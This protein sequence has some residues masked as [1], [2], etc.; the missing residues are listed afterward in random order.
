MEDDL[1]EV[2]DGLRPVTPELV[3]ALLGVVEGL[4]S[5][6]AAAVAGEEYEAQVALSQRALT[7]AVGGGAPEEPVA[8][9]PPPEQAPEPA[10]ERT[11][12]PVSD[13]TPAPGSTAPDPMPTAPEP[14]AAGRLV[15]SVQERL[16]VPI[17]RLDELVRLVGETVAGQLR[18]GVLL[19]QALGRDPEGLEE[20]RSF[21]HIL[22]EL[23]G[24]AMRTRMVPV[25][26]AEPGLQRAIRELSRARGKQVRLEVLGG[27]TELDRRVLDQLNEV[28]LHLVRNAVDHGLESPDDR[29]AAGKGR[30]GNIVL[31]ATQN[32]SE[33]VVVVSDDGRGIDLDR[34]RERVKARGGLQRELNDEEAMGVIFSPGFSTSAQVDEVSGRGVG[35]DVVRT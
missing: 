8:P 2:R 3:D 1:S 21:T 23:Q 15:A 32:R 29:V 11:P 4:T 20:F 31:A 30:E 6:V 19:R 35:L 33:A 5:T 28:L 18:L 9:P 14:G 27:E 7:H 12:V 17:E 13:R 22:Q 25:S 34:V 10:S 26:K 16:A 24:V